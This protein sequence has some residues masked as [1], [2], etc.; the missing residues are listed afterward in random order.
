[1]N[2]EKQPSLLGGCFFGGIE[3][4]WTLTIAHTPLKRARLPIPPQ[5]QILSFNLAILAQVFLF[6]KVLW[7]KFWQS[8]QKIW[9]YAQYVH[10]AQSFFV[11]QKMSKKQKKWFFLFDLMPMIF[12]Q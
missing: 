6:V 2:N 1:M 7:Q 10:F 3:G 4:T 11:L 9:I 12:L 8:P 5:S